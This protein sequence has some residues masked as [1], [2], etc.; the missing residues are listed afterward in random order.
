M[1]IGNNHE[2]KSIMLSCIAAVAIVAIVGKK[3]F[4]SHAFES[5]DLLMQNVEALSLGTSEYVDNK[6]TVRRARA[7]SCW[8]KSTNYSKCPITEHGTNC[9][10]YTIEWFFDHEM[11]HCMEISVEKYKKDG[12][13]TLCK[14]QD[15]QCAGHKSSSK[16]QNETGHTY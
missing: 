6:I 5:S 16:P 3:T 12:T 14:T 15:V 10:I 13:W 7:G 1:G 9:R 2:E 4:Q 8:K 11:Y